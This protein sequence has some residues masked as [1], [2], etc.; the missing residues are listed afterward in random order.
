[1]RPKK[2]EGEKSLMGSFVMCLIGEEKTRKACRIF[3][4]NLNGIV[5]FKDLSMDD[6]LLLRWFLD[7]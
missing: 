1:M 7:N 6:I 5:Q 3:V 2:E 4:K